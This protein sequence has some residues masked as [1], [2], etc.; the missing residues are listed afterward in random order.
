MGRPL[1]LLDIIFSGTENKNKEGPEHVPTLSQ[2]F[3]K[4]SSK[5]IC[6]KDY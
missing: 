1:P 4:K 6:E 3:H 2:G 5:A